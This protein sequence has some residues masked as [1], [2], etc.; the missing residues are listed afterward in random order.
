MDSAASWRL[1]VTVVA[2]AILLLAAGAV[3]YIA[4]RSFSPAFGPELA[5]SAA[6]VADGLSGRIDRALSLGIP[7]N[8]LE[9]VEAA[10]DNALERSP[11]IGG[12][13]LAAP[14]GSLLATSGTELPEILGDLDDYVL[15]ERTV[16]T[17]GARVIVAVT[18]DYGAS[19]ARDVLLDVI[20]VA[21]VACLVAFELMLFVAQRAT[22]GLREL[23]EAADRAAAGDFTAVPRGEFPRTCRSCGGGL[24]GDDAAGQRQYHGHLNGG[25]GISDRSDAPTPAT[26]PLR[27]GR[28]AVTPVP[29]RLCR[30][31]GRSG[32]RSKPEFG[33]R[34]ADQRVHVRLGVQPADRCRLVRALRP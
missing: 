13:A 15:T 24:F 4:W 27:L 9:G 5:Q 22:A 29:A 31:S 2:L 1:N 33:G 19:V 30:R 18:A 11:E 20:T 28:G 26:V 8:E 17:Q 34:T 32:V 10:F 3:G 16:G 23:D 6:R 14:D 12:I 21:V 7:L 25:L